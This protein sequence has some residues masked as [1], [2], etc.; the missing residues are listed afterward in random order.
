MPALDFP[1]SQRLL[2]ALDDAVRK[3]CPASTTDALRQALCGLMRDTDVGLPASVRQA[4]SDRHA[5]RGT[6]RSE[7]LG[8]S[9]SHDHAGMWCIEGV[10]RGQIEVTPYERA[11]CDS[12]PYR[13]ESRGTLPA[14]SGSAGSL[15]PP[16]EH[17]A[18]RNPGDDAIAVS[19]HINRGSM[20]S[21]A[22]FRPAR[23]NWYDCDQC[24]LSQDRTH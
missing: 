24:Q 16:R 11:E 22:V 17:P 23:E 8:Y 3:D 21:I 2:E 12:G 14:G 7:D 4:A 6:C 10:R 5:R 13:F 20:T 19:L 1:G 18:I 9:S 15:I